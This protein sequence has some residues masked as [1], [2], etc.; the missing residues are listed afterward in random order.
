V[1]LLKEHDELNVTLATLEQ[2]LP[3]ETAEVT[4]LEGAITRIAA[5]RKL[6]PAGACRG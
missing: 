6:G 5:E 4:K 3:A 1:Q 2:A